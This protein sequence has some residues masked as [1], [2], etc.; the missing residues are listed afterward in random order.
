MAFREYYGY[1]IHQLRDIFH[2]EVKHDDLFATLEPSHQTYPELQRR[3]NHSVLRIKSVT[4]DNEATRKG[5]L[6]TPVVAE[7]CF[8]LNLGVFL[9]KELSVPADQ[10]PELPHQLNGK[11]DYALSLDLFDCIFPV[12]AVIEAKPSELSKGI[13]QCLSE[14]VAT[15]TLFDQQQQI[16]GIISDGEVWEF[17]LLHNQTLTLDHSNY[18]VSHV[19]DILDR[20]GYIVQHMSEQRC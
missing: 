12:I 11:C 13:G 3:L 4:A 1:P 10:T 5:L 6:V 7:A 19:S 8:L 14:L 16:Y 9:E 18:Y 20:I 15:L 17:M 2:V